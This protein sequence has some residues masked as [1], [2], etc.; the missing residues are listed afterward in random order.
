[1]KS[2]LKDL[3]EKGKVTRPWLGVGI[4]GVTEELAQYFGLNKAEG[5]VIS[6][7]VPGSP[8]DNAGLRR[9]DVIQ[10]FDGKPINNPEE[11]VAAIEKTPIGKKVAALVWRDK[12][13]RYITV[14][15]GEKGQTN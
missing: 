7:V 15:I 9:G 11:L 13:T 4:Q 12:Q 3:M 14:T 6:N 5:A 2:V 1:M 10:E 8:A